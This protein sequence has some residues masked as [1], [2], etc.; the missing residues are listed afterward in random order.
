MLFRRG[1]GFQIPQLRRPELVLAGCARKDLWFRTHLSEVES[2]DPE[3]H[4]KRL[5]LRVGQLRTGG[6]LFEDVFRINEY[7]PKRI[8]KS[9]NH[10]Q[11]SYSKFNNV[12]WMVTT[13]YLTTK[14]AE[15]KGG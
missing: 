4:L 15:R 6:E 8:T 11:V 14:E 12:F 2:L 10:F 5:P 13:F 1:F 3:A 7:T 9:F